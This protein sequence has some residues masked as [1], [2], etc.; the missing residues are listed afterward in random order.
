M[1][2]RMGAR[3]DELHLHHPLKGASCGEVGVGSS[4]V[5]EVAVDLAVVSLWTFHA[6]MWW[7]RRALWSL[8]RERSDRGKVGKSGGPVYGLCS[9]V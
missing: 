1:R 6:C 5:V 8:H 7:R 3:P 4:D 2:L 9:F